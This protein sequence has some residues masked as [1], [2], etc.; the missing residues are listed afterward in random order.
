MRAV[1]ASIGGTRAS[2]EA[3][4]SKALRL[5]HSSKSFMAGIRGCALLWVCVSTRIW[6]SRDRSRR[7]SSTEPPWNRLVCRSG[8]L[9]QNTVDHGEIF[10][11]ADH[12]QQ[13]RFLV[14]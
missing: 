9:L 10:V 8:Q 2:T 1:N 11:R 3:A 4:W 14:E 7:S 13:F 6:R 12:D 5:T